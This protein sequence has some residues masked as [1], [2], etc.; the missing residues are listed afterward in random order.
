MIGDLEL[1]R[2]RASNVLCRITPLDD[3]LGALFLPCKAQRPG[4]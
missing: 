1:L 4:P 3:F 2:L